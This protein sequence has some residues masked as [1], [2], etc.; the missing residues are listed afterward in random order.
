MAAPSVRKL[1]TITGSSV[2]KNTQTNKKNKS[3]SAS[4]KTSSVRVL[5]STVKPVAKITN[6]TD[7]VSATQEKTSSVDSTRASGLRGNIIKGVGSK[8]SSNYTSISQPASSGGTIA[9]LEQ[10]ISDLETKMVKKQDVLEYGDGINLDDNTVS[11]SQEIVSLPE[12]VDKINQEVYEINQEIDNLNEQISTATLPEN[13]Y[14]IDET[15]AYLQQNYYTKQYI[16][17]KVN[18][19]EIAGQTYNA[20]TGLGLT[21]GATADSPATIGLDVATSANTTYIFKTDADG[22]GTWQALKVQNN[23]DPEF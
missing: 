22:N 19:L 7:S 8:L 14:N 11:L 21:P 6:K 23:W 15:K 4:K 17:Q 3:S 12:K 9:N 5:G 1:G 16:D 2:Y 13:Y 18:S 20:G 10:H